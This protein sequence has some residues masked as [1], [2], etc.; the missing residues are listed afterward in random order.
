MK[1]LKIL[2]GFLWC[3]SFLTH[4]MGVDD[5]PILTKV[6]GEI[7]T[8]KADGANLRVW[9]A[10]VW[11]GKDLEKIWIKSEGEKLNG[12][13]IEAELQILYSK[14]VAPFWD[15]QYGIKKDLQPTPDRTWGV[16]AAKGMAPYL[17]EVDASLF[18][19][20]S[21]RVSMR[22]DAEYEYMISQKLILSSE[23]ELNI[24]S[25]DDEAI[26][27]G[28]GLSNIEAGLRLS[29]ELSREFS[30]YIGINWGKK[31]G[32]TATFS[33]SEGEDVEDSKIVT[34]VRFW[35]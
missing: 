17:F 35:F 22:L 21:G 20:E 23:I 4:A 8:R 3:L 10:N 9:N 5:D 18:I 7:E 34:G 19:G 2:M 13:T 1:N 14:A 6:M 27:I 30:P 29:Y 31:Y 11:I 28:K 32:N 16:I 12:K 26:S 25:K 15:L 24:F 33:S